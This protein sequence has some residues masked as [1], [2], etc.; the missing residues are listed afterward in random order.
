MKQCKVMCD[1]LETTHEITKHVKYSPQ[2]EAIFQKLKESLQF[3]WVHSIN[4]LYGNLLG[5]LVLNH[6]DNTLQHKSMSAAEGQVLAKMIVETHQSIY[7]DK[8]FD[9]FWECSM[10]KAEI[11]EVDEPRLPR[12]R[13]LP[14]DSLTYLCASNLP[15]CN[16]EPRTSKLSDAFTHT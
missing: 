8:S 5:Q 14:N 3:K 6:I 11:L 1:A 10:K 16:N 15:S 12:Q 7:D 2:R 4:Y 13:K 9:L